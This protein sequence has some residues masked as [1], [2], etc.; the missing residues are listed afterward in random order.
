MGIGEYSGRLCGTVRKRRDSLDGSSVFKFDC[1]LEIPLKHMEWV[2]SKELKDG[3]RV[4]FTL[5][6][7]DINRHTHEFKCSCGMAVK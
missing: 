3:D 6:D 1:G 5:R 7:I 4:S 2:V